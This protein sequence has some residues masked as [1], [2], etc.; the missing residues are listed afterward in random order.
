MTELADNIVHFARTLRRAGFPLGTGQINEAMRA[1]DT[2]GIT[3]RDDLRSALFATLVS[4][5]GQRP[6][7]DQAFDAFWRDPGLFEKA[8]AALLPQT[9]VPPTDLPPTAGARRIA[10]A[11]RGQAEPRT[12]ENRV[13]LE[14]DARDTASGDEILAAK[15]FEQMSNDE[16]ARA[17]S[18]LAHMNWSLPEQT[19]RRT[20]PAARGHAFDLRRTLRKS[21]KTGGNIIR[22]ERRSRQTRE[23]PLVVL[24]DISGSMSGYAR[25]C[26]H[27]L[28]G[29]THAR[30]V[31]GRAMHTFLFGTR[32]TNVTRA[33]RL[34][35]PD[36]ALSKV[37]SLTPD[38]DGGTR[39]ADA[40]VRFNRDWSRRVLGQG[41]VVLLITDGLERDDVSTLAQAA[42]RLHRST[43]RL[44]WLNPL[45]RY[46]EF[47]PKAQ[48]VRALLA[49]VDELRPVHNLTSMADLADALAG[50]PL[51]DRLQR[52]KDRA[53]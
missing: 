27:F 6:I 24:C 3:R 11:L 1:V 44:I 46:D 9:L 10:E 32:L 38:W 47:A 16:I 21:L 2:I 22:L 35:D 18:V 5:P 20:Q 53:A 31:R 30:R 8:M 52:T 37:A 12:G 15:D 50:R 43:R 39:I 14:L 40:L 48:G 36:E 41:A 29:L 34:R 49:H 13:Q 26:L 17:K 19:S 45:L 51:N 28:H 25:M 4:H 42:E 23:P 7:F 33:L